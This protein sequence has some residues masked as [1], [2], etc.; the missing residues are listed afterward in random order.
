MTESNTNQ[1]NTQGQDTSE[2][3]REQVSVNATPAETGGK[4]Q[5]EKQPRTFTQDE[6]NQIVSDRLARERAK[7]TESEGSPIDEREQALTTRENALRCQ[8]FINENVSRYPRELLKA[9]DTSNFD[10]FKTQ[11][12]KFLEVFPMI[13]RDAPKIKISGATPGASFGVVRDMLGE[14]FRPK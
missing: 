4:S 10:S 14:M 7:N 1:M 11:A 13:A 9:L 12:D 2:Q 6:V 8:E 5:N 3:N